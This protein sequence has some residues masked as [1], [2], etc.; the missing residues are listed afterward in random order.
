LHRSL[1]INKL[2]IYDAAGYLRAAP[3]VSDVA[4]IITKKMTVAEVLEINPAAARIL[5][6]EGMSCVG[7]SVARMETLEEG[8]GAHDIDVDA[9]V[10][11]LNEL[12][13]NA[14]TKGEDQT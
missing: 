12:L 4:R 13:G 3:E 7:C 11:R 14:E 5:L 1:Y 9:L 6:D 10:A 8:A 2:S